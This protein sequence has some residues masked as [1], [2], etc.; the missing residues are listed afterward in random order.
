MKE[1]PLTQGYIALVEDADYEAVS[2]F[3]WCATKIGRRVYATHSIKKPDGSRT[4]QLL[5]RF[6][7]PD[8]PEVDH[9]NGNGLDN[10]RHNL[11]SATS[12]QNLHGFQ[13]KRKGVSSQFRGVSWYALRALW[14][15][16]IGVNYQRVFL[17]RFKT[18]L[19]AALAYDK[20]A[21]KYFGEIAQLNFPVHNT[22]QL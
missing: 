12:Q 20:A 8:A 6:L 4:T 17:G 10:Q 21:Y 15:A 7:V 14:K 11:R 9:K 1:I 18:E 13:R 5:H 19:E 3:K 16:E 2:Q 22:T